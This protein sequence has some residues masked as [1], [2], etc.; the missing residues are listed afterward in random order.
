[1]PSSRCSARPP[2]PP[3]DGARTPLA[4][5]ARLPFGCTARCHAVRVLTTVV[6]ILAGITAWCVASLALALV[7]GPLVRR[8]DRGRRTVRPAVPIRPA[9]MTGAIPLPIAQ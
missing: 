5:A 8:S 1:M 4:G 6:L 2:P 7:V 9:P 3:A